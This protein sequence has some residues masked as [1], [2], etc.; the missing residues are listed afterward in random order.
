MMQ[1]AALLPIEHPAAGLSKTLREDWS[2]CSYAR[3]LRM[4]FAGKLYGAR[5][6]RQRERPLVPPW[7]RTI[8]A[9][10]RQGAR[11][12]VTLVRPVSRL[13]DTAPAA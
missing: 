4:C 8:D 9:L 1:V 3:H 10:A 12:K 13:P 2:Y 5:A 11:F 7:H 6:A